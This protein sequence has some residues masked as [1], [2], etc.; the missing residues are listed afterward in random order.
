MIYARISA[1]G[2]NVL[3]Q[4]QSVLGTRM[5]YVRRFQYSHVSWNQALQDILVL[6][7]QQDPSPPYFGYFSPQ[8][9]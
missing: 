2:G 9:N 8:W 1:N 5:V 6:C 7:F 4:G 3:K